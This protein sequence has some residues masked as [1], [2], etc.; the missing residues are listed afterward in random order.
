[1]G[2]GEG[3]GWV[4][5]GGWVWGVGGWVGGERLC[6][7]GPGPLAIEAGLGPNCPGP[8]GNSPGP[9]NPRCGG[10][11]IPQDCLHQ[12]DTGDYSWHGYKTTA[13]RRQHDIMFGCDDNTYG[14]TLQNT[15]QVPPILLTKVV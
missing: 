14:K 3:E 6:P 11:I 13:N 2:V 10:P 9:F 12:V 4:G 7:N 5:V 8:L 1:M 15:P